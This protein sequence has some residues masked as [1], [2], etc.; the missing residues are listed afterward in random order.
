MS[1]SQRCKHAWL[2]GRE[3]VV[4]AMGGR[5]TDAVCTKQGEGGREGYAACRM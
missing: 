2:A 5:A 1:G 4:S 3:V